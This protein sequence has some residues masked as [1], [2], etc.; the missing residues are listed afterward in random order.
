MRGWHRLAATLAAA[1]VVAACGGGGGGGGFPGGQGILSGR[2]F[3]DAGTR[4]FGLLGEQVP[5]KG[6]GTS[7]RR[8]P[9]T[10]RGKSS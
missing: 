2:V 8:S 4:T 6:T 10:R 9:R 7:R 5:P 1:A 3:V